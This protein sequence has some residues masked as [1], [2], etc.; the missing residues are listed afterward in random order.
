MDKARG[1]KKAVD[2]MIALSGRC[3]YP[4]DRVLYISHCFNEETASSCKTGNEQIIWFEDVKITH[5]HGLLQP[6]R[7][8][9]ADYCFLVCQ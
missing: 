7:V 6:M 4:K 5:T 3:K 9:K 2:K 8:K 1:F